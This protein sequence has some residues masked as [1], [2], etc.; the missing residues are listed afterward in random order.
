MHPFRISGPA[1]CALAAMLAIS[2]VFAQDPRAPVPVRALAPAER[3]AATGD[4][5]MLVFPSGVIDPRDQRL[6]APAY[7]LQ[8]PHGDRYGLVQMHDVRA[9]TLDRLRGLGVEVL[10]YQPNNAY[11]VAWSPR[12]RQRL[13]QHPDVRWAGEFSAEM[14]IAPPLLDPATAP[15]RS[16][17]GRTD[18]GHAVEILGFPGVSAN[19]LR[20]AVEKAVPG[21][22]LLNIFERNRYPAVEVWVTVADLPRLV[23]TMAAESRV[24]WLAPATQPVLHNRDSVEVIQANTGI[25]AP[26]LPTVTPIWDQDLIGTGQ[27]VAVMDSGLDRNEDWF[28]AWDDGSGPNTVLT[29]AESPALPNIGTT[30]PDRKVFGYW[31]QPGSTAYDSSVFG[32][33]CNPFGFHGTHVTGTVAGDSNTRS[34][35]TAPNYDAGD[36]MAPN[37]QILFQDIGNDTSSCLSIQDFGGSLQQA[38]DGGARVHSNSWG[39]AGDGSYNSNSGA[40][41][42][43]TRL[44]EELLVVVAA[45]NDGLGGSQ[46]VGPPATAKNAVAVGYLLHGD[47]TTANSQSGQGPTA[48][49]RHKPDIQ[50]PGTGIV[51]AAGDSDNSGTIDPPVTSP[52]SGTSMAT[53]A[54]AG[55]AAL[56]RQYFEEGFYP[57]GARNAA[58]EYAPTGALM[59]AVLLN[60]TNLDDFPI[61][62]NVYG[63]G[64]I[65]L[66][67]NLYFAGDDRYLRQ[68]DVPH[69]AGLATGDE[70]SYSV[71]VTAGEELRV[72]L[73][74]FDVAG[75]VGAGT[76]L[77]NNLDLEV[78]APGGSVFLG[79]VFSGGQSTAGG[80]ADD[81]NTVEQVRLTSPSSGTYEIRVDGAAVP[82]NGENY[83]DRQG[84]AVVL[85]AAAPPAAAMSAPGSV[86]AS[87]NGAAGIDVSFDPVS[88]AAG[89]NVY[90]ASGDCDTASD[91][92]FRLVGHADTTAFTDTRVIGG[93][94]YSYVVRA[95]NSEREGPPSS[96]GAAAVA[97]STADC[98]LVPDFDQTSVAAADT[99]GD[100][101]GIELDWAAGSSNCPAGT[102]MRY[103]VYRSTDPLFTPA[104]GNLVAADLDGV[105]EWTDPNVMP[106]T[107]YFYVVRAED[108]SHPT[109]G[110]QTSGTR[111]VQAISTGDGSVPGTFNDDPDAVSYMFVEEPWSVSDDRAA[112]GSFSYRSAPDGATEYI[113]NTCTHVTTPDIELQAGSP[114]LSFDAFYDIEPD[115]DGV[116]LEISTNGGSSWSILTPDGGYP[117][118]FSM[119][120]S[121]PI[122][123]CG[124]PASQGAYNGDTGGT[125]DTETVD[126]SAFAGQTVRIRWSFSTDPGAQF[127]GFYLDDIA[128]TDASTPQMCFVSEEIF[129]DGFEAIV[130]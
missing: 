79:N 109:D 62:D 74:W 39:A 30:H 16:F 83:S 99:A 121:P 78:E 107:K 108:G 130:P 89:Y 50:A 102:G 119:T 100:M 28:V 115:W 125:F 96:C 90:R 21:A 8:P 112:T 49:G 11:I 97:T 69:T 17:Q 92:D 9:G 88:G 55:G 120:G 111:A 35:P 67:G 22:K 25:S 58:D 20:A 29:D 57:T 122:N 118:D 128:I 15:V 126:L 114:S 5:N 41:D 56:A 106:D 31:V 51:S 116:V 13:Q 110:N 101:C 6:S 48:D 54:V 52:K 95:E 59:K 47:S 77:V 63:W 105:S 127:E 65:W 4:D 43:V 91:L 10:A 34:T 26:G 61:F 12:L 2:G 76:Q 80:S 46:T 18:P 129:A 66:D 37:A 53:P 23:E 71:D 85:S 75:S 82:G 44:N 81:L 72:T 87:D 70:D 3:A 27:I 94:E 93:Y 98:G 60:G 45:G 123:I 84:Y 42:H 113:P 104:P 24:Y 7:S 14:K 32:G 64:R 103:N 1:A 73:V 86:T 40:L 36:G 68:W 38:Y 19:G 33:S 117:G 124:F